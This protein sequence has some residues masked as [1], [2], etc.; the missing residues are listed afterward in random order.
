MK[1]TALALVTVV[2]LASC[3]GDDSA[4]TAT[5]AATSTAT[6]AGTSTDAPVATDAV[7]AGAAD[8]VLSVPEEFTTIQEAVDAA[9]PGDLVLISPGVYNEAV[10]VTTD[11]I[12]IRGLDRNEVVLDG[13]FE[14]DNGVRVL[15]ASGVAVEN[16]T[17]QNYTNNGVFWTSVDGYRGSYITAYRNG[18]YGVY[19][20][21]SINGLLEHSYA[22][23]SPD[24]GF[25]IGQCYECNAVMDDVISE[26]NGLGYSGTTSGGNLLH[27][28]QPLQQ[29]P[30]RHQRQLGHLRAVLPA[31]SGHD[32]RQH[33][34]RQQPGATPRRSTTR[35]LAMNNGILVDGGIGN[36]I[37]RNLVYD[38]TKVGIGLMPFLEYEPNDAEPS[39]DTWDLPCSETATCRWPIPTRSRRSCGHAKENRVV[40]NVVEGSGVA[41]LAVSAVDAALARDRSHHPR[42]LLRRQRVHHER[43]DR[44]RRRCFPCEGTGSGGDWLRAISTW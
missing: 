18:D 13:Q 20:F 9:S 1:K 5:D 6:D 23:G 40:G 43:T 39:E 29:Q 21:D 2:I 3:G 22:S 34:V 24:A 14:L 41:D 4:S 16:L 10:N 30:R 42:Q 31:A 19:A 28:Q 32:R 36:V 12:T 35:I 38:Q 27:R 17:A 7:D 33:R 26:Y 8:G 37:E 11:E 25:Y 44:H 15:G